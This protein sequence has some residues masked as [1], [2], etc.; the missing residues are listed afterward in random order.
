MHKDLGT[1]AGTQDENTGEKTDLNTRVLMKTSDKG[2]AEKTVRRG[3]ETGGEKSQTHP[4]MNLQ[5]KTGNV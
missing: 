3:Q 5:N 2:S 4:R 1:D